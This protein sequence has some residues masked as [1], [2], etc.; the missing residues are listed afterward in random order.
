MSLTERHVLIRE[1]SS[2][3]IV[4]LNSKAS[5]TRLPIKVDGAAMNP[6][7][8]TVALRAGAALTMYSLDMNAKIKTT[9]LEGQTVVFMKWIDSK[10]VGIVTTDRVYHWSLEGSS[11]PEVVFERAAHPNPVQIINYQ[12]S[13]D[14]KWLMLNGIS[15]DEQKQV[16]GVLQI[17][18]CELKQSQP[19]LN[20]PAACFARVTLD[21][22]TD[23]S[24]ILSFARKDPATNTFTLNM[25]EV[26][27]PAGQAFT[28]QQQL[29]MQEG[30]FPI[31][32]L[33]DPKMSI[34]FIITQAG[35]L[36]VYE[37]QSGKPIFAHR[38]STVSMFTSCVHSTEGIVAVDQKG[39]VAHFFLDKK[40]CVAYI[41]NTMKDMELGVQMAR[42]Y[43]L[44][45]ADHIFKAQF[46]KL[47][48]EGRSQ[49]AMELAASSPQLRTTETLNALRNAGGNLVWTYFQSLLSKGS[50]N[51]VESVELVKPVLAKG[52]AGFDH[53]KNWIKEGKIEPSEPLGDVLL[54][55]FPPL[56]LSVYIRVNAHAKVV[57]TFV[58]LAAAEKDDQE[59]KKE[60]L[61]NVL[62]YPRRNNAPAP[63][64]NGL[65]RLAAQLDSAT[66]KELASLLLNAEDGA[67]IN[68]DQ[69]TDMFFGAQD[70]KNG[71]AILLEYLRVRGDRPEDAALQ[72]KL[73]K[74]NLMFAPHVAK[75]LMET[76]DF[77]LSHFNKP[78]I[79]TLCERN[80]L[81]RAALE[82]YTDP[83]SIKRVL[84]SVPLPH[85]ELKLEFLLEYFG[86]LSSEM[87]IE[88]LR[89]LLKVN[90]QA[91]L[92]VVVEI[93][94]K[95][96][97]HY[98]ID[99]LIS[100]YEDFKT[101]FG[102]YHFL[103]SFVNFSTNSAVVFKYI[104]AASKMG[105]AA[106]KEIERV[107]RENNNYDPKEVKDFLLQ[108]SFSV[109]DPRPLIYVCSR[110][111]YLEELITFLMNNNLFRFIEV[112][113]QQKAP[114]SAPAVIGTLL[115]LNAP[116]DQIKKLIEGL[117]QPAD[118]P[119][120]VNTLCEAIEKRNRLRLLRPWLE[121][122]AQEDSKDPHVYTSLAKIYVD[123]GNN[124]RHFLETNKLYDHLAVGRFCESRDPPLAIVV[125]RMGK[126]DKE[127][128]NVTNKNGFFKE[129]AQY[130][131]ER[132]DL[133][134]WASVLQADNPYRRS[135]IDQVVSVA[136]PQSHSPEQVTVAVKAFMNA[137]IPNELIDLL[138]R[139]MLNGGENSHFRENKPLQNL[140]IL[141]ACKSA[142]DRV[143]E[144]VKRLDNYDVN[145]VTSFCLLD[146]H[147]LYEEAFYV[148][149]KHNR[150]ADAATVLITNI[151]D[152]T[153]A[154]EFAGT[155]DIPDV[156][157][158]LA[159]AQLNANQ[160]RDAIKSYIR[161]DVAT[162]FS[163]VIAAVGAANDDE[164]YKDLISYLKM[165]RTKSKDSAI[166]N[167]LVY[168]FARINDL[169]SLEEFVQ[170]P[171]TAKLLDCGDRIFR[172]DRYQAARII[173]TQISNFAK[174]AKC[175]VKLE[176]WQEAVDAARKAKT[177]DTWMFVCFACV[178]AQQFR[179][180][181]ICGLNVVG[182]MEQLKALV[183][184]YENKGYFAELIQL[185][186][187]AINLERPHQGIFTQLGVAYARYKEEKMMEFVKLYHSRSNIAQL[188]TACRQNLLWTEAVF[189]SQQYEQYENAVEMMMEHASQ[190]WVH[191]LFKE[192]L[193][194]CSNNDILY[195]AI[196]FYLEQ[197]PLLLNDLLVELEKKLDHSRVVYKIR[198]LRNPAIRE[199]LALIKVYLLHVQ[200]ADLQ[201]VNDAVND[202]CILEEN[203]KALR[204]SIEDH[205]AYDQHSLASRLENHELVEF[206]R[207]RY[208]QL[209]PSHGV[210]Y[211]CLCNREGRGERTES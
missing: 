119:D 175:L 140:L 34:L 76:D 202:L 87:G 82:L 199:P 120:W 65:V 133:D 59:K 5:P 72:T 143:M 50:L 186:E 52:P 155:V 171:N 97:E 131:V 105:A 165:A 207:I 100:L 160:V 80:G 7:S 126:C 48:S 153:R 180:A 129:Q 164:L 23:P 95:W 174:L 29:R 141:T 93:S 135:V 83:S 122:R 103:G 56:A 209:P 116:E 112:F 32:M 193:A 127:L 22:R 167:E 114:K 40:N 102:L 200:H 36:F 195:R 136:L 182:V 15:A 64:Y 74:F 191:N 17:F 92:P 203:H 69:V 71:S 104:E 196:D 84:T 154:A 168:S 111:D 123:G 187:A 146:E 57:Q 43:N 132:Q 10:T 205:K 210:T 110:F 204:T 184:H 169:P 9:N 75:A 51:A 197:H 185:L 44:E 66:G 14:G 178:D 107:C 31:G 162:K 68:I 90:L 198:N 21:G 177:A 18:S 170:T 142:K 35:F 125:Y 208:V 45:G 211:H 96:H 73:L 163:E 118:D 201:P 53:I 39:R 79:A 151:G 158:L 139:L 89:E 11:D 8:K 166:D 173:Y 62:E 30:D 148:F 37:M 26:G 1:E 101:N 91:N 47:M 113:V 49:E 25:V 99:K 121:A 88:I 55:V 3:A 12:A 145:K 24:T 179:P 137:D 109:Q 115:D 194:K 183:S 189:L 19:N 70:V 176:L 161:A 138:D 192:L 81:F 4:D 46:A 117:L 152:L 172:E 134:A 16:S 42:R 6:A 20:A 108:Q 78:E 147:K 41:C 33:A 86:K 181:Q 157:A 13:G 149:K 124:P 61:R 159:D 77:K 106:I 188:I 156:W 38:A 67:K 54:P 94:K 150:F 63:D 58:R 206:R 2:V 144:Y 27:A 28:K 130:L 60:Y 190:A 128:I 98:G 85:P